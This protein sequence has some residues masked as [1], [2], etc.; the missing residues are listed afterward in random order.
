MYKSGILGLGIVGALW[1]EWP[2][3][4]ESALDSS[5]QGSVSLEP[6]SQSVQQAD[7]TG[8]LV[9][10]LSQNRLLPTS[11]DAIKTMTHQVRSTSELI[12]LNRSF[13]R[14]LQQLP[15]IGKVL[16]DRIVT[17]RS[18][19]GPFQQV[20]DLEGVVGIGEKR[21]KRLRPFVTI[22]ESNS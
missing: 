17:Y 4:P 13:Q 1:V 22:E 3:P 8:T 19:H 12:D 15:G 5:L 16:A 2:S 14:E 11:D 7:R 21:L 10:S 20:S 6:L 9:P 18:T